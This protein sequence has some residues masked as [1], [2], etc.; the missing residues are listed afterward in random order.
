MPTRCWR[1]QHRRLPLSV[2]QCQ[3]R[4]CPKRDNAWAGSTKIRVTRS[5]G[6]LRLLHPKQRS[7]ILCMAE[8]TTSFN[9][10]ALWQHEGLSIQIPLRLVGSQLSIVAMLHFS[11]GQF[12]HVFIFLASHIQWVAG[13]LYLGVKRPGREADHSPPSSVEV[14]NAWSYIFTP[15]IRLHGVVFS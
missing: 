7:R 13:S 2:L 15:P 5:Y 12:F 11:P 8:Q 10:H 6:E 14:K 4:Y 9:K 3:T 1:S